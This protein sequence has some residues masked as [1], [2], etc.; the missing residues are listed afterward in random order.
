MGRRGVLP[1]GTPDPRQATLPPKPVV[2]SRLDLLTEHHPHLRDKRAQLA[3]LDGAKCGHCGH[4]WLAHFDGQVG[5]TCACHFTINGFAACD[6]LEFIAND[7]E[8]AAAL[9]LMDP[10]DPL[11]AEATRAESERRRG[12]T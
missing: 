8:Q 1:T 11:V 12:G 6:C 3:C 2:K 10:S 7:V 4:V 5:V 9:K